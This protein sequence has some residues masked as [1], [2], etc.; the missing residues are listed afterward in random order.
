MSSGRIHHFARAG[1]PLLLALVVACTQATPGA[2][3]A[4]G[5]AAATAAATPSGPSGTLTVAMRGDIQSTHPYLSYDIVGISY[6]YNVFDALVE[7]DFDGKIVPALAESWKVDGKN[8][9]FALRKGVKFHNG[10]PLTAADVKF[11]IDTLKSKELNSGQAG[12]FGAVQHIM[13]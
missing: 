1:L 10:D 7:W 3:T 11:S 6:R 2:T 4:P 8:I 9:T 12:N 13:A 5:T